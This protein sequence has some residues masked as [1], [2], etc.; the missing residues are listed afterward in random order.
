M[1]GDRLKL[2]DGFELR[3]GGQRVA[4]PMSAQRLIAYL[5]VH[6]HRLRRVHVA[7]ALW[8]DT[9]EERAFANLRSALWRLQHAGGSLVD[10]GGGTIGLHPE[11]RVD[12]HDAA[13]LAGALLELRPGATRPGVSWRILKGEL[14]PDWDEDWLAVEREHQRHLSLQA[15]EALAD[16]MLMGGNVGPALEIALA[17]Y[18]REPLRESAH[19]LLVRVHLDSG[20]SFEAIR[21]YRMYEGMT[22][23]RLGLPPSPHMH[24]LVRGLLPG[25]PLAPT[26]AA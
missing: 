1:N 2:L 19:R 26:A 21:Q 11:L 23:S 25:E 20:N 10:A 9:P 7:G 16:D 22:L 8:M 4:L 17:V 3:C 24:D 6:P 15:L 13:G 14:L 18:A 12:L 5:A